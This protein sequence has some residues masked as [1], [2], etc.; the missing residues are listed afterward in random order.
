MS[1]T[2]WYR[3]FLGKNKVMAL[4]L[5]RTP[6]EEPKENLHKI[7]QV[8][9][10]VLWT[11]RYTQFNV[12]CLQY[13]EGNSGLLFTSRPKMEVLRLVFQSLLLALSR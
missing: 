3:F 13:L 7:S 2:K 5:G 12:S 1:M 4:A 8:A 6:E 11:G 10:A 9:L